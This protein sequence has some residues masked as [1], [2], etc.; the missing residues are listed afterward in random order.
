MIAERG[1]ES[2]WRLKVPQ[3]TLIIPATRNSAPHILFQIA[4]QVIFGLVSSSI[5]RLTLV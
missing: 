3:M 1:A 4:F 5:M 2:G